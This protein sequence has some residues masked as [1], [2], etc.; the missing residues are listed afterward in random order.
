MKSG[1]RQL[2]GRRAKEHI[3]GG[4]RELEGDVESFQE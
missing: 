4:M 3:T 2:S 1:D